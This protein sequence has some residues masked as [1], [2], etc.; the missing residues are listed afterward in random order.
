MNNIQQ[1]K[2]RQLHI[3][4]KR[5][6]DG[7]LVGD[8]VTA[9]R[10]YGCEFHQIR[11][12]Q[13]GDDVRFIDWRSSARLGKLLVK[14]CLQERNRTVIVAVD[15]SSSSLF[16]AYGAR[17]EKLREAAATLLFAAHFARDSVGL[18][19]FSDTVNLYIPEKNTPSHVHVL[20][21]HLYA[22]QINPGRSTNLEKLFSYVA[23]RWNKNAI[24]F[25]VSDFINTGFE[26]GLCAAAHRSDIV[27]ARVVDDV[28]REITTSGFITIE[29][30]ETGHAVLAHLGGAHVQQALSARICAQDELFARMGVDVVDIGVGQDVCG[31]LVDFFKKRMI[32][33]SV[34]VG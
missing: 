3:V 7:P 13:T 2:I 1:Q 11:S 18:I 21:E 5:L 22:C 8:D 25:V 26:R 19:L 23:Q 16:G 30:L 17:I 27:A 9:R 6:M 15:I 31:V 33:A 28:E 4:T 29:D 32:H 20:L 14:E 10:G 24:V 34:R 12:Y